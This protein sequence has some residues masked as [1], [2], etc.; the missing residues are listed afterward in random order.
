MT[1]RLRDR[2]L[3]IGWSILLHA[4][5]VAALAWGLWHFEREPP[6]PQQLAI[7]A[8]VV[9]ARSLS[10]GERRE[11]QER[12]RRAQLERAARERA[13]AQ[14]RAQEA[15][16]RAKAEA[17]Q[18]A[19]A[20]RQ[21]AANREAERQA[22]ARRREEAERR[23]REDAER[24]A[25]L[26]RA[27]AERAAAARAAVEA[28]Q[29]AERE[30]REVELR[31]GIE[32]EERARTAAASG[33]RAQWVAQIAARIQR[34][35]IQPP[36]ARPGIDCVLHMTQV[37]GGEVVNVRIGECNG[38]AAVRQSIEAA[39]YRASPLPSPPDPA[40]FERNLEVRFRPQVE[41]G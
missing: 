31:R 10:S 30:A 8:T 11:Q 35:W 5:I 22:Q 32:A 24:R 40:L 28:R 18:R 21:A 23:T 20:E 3:P 2:W 25:A 15:R 26:E 41:A 39:A 6:P 38:D 27:A 17:E 19:E 14:A 37:P 4:G 29:R 7:E 34:A 1:G 16:R 33:L 13:D 36:A 12:E 9:D